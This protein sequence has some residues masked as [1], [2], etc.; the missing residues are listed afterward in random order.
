MEHLGAK[1]LDQLE[2]QLDQTLKQIRSTKVFKSYVCIRRGLF[3][4]DMCLEFYNRVDFIFGQLVLVP[5]NLYRCVLSL[6]PSLLIINHYISLTFSSNHLLCVCPQL[7][8]SLWFSFRNKIVVYIFFKTLSI[9]YLIEKPRCF[10]TIILWYFYY[11][12][13]SYELWYI[14]LADAVLAWST[15]WPSKEGIYIDA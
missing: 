4:L 11:Q 10:W 3:I 8:S 13:N 14:C 1:E 9:T 15:F 12:I 2:H 5:L 6:S 7:S